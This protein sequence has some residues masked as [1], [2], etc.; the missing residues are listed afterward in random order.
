MADLT[1]RREEG[2]GAMTELVVRVPDT[3]WNGLDAVVEIIDIRHQVPQQ[4]EAL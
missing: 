1:L 2:D 3:A 4:R